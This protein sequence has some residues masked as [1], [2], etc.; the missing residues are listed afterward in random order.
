[1]HVAVLGSGLAGLT[2]AGLLARKGHRVSLYEQHPE[3]GGVTSGIGKDGFRWDLGQMLMPDLGP[4]E[5]GRSVLEELGISDQ[6]AVTRGCRANV[7]PDFAILRPD[8]CSGPYWRREFFKEIFPEDADG[9][10]RYYE[11]YDRVHDLLGLSNQSGLG[12]R[13][14][15]LLGALRIRRIKSWSAEQ[16]LDAFFSS[17]KLKAVFSHILADYSTYPRDFPGLIIPIINPEA[18]YDERV[19]LE[20]GGHTRRSS[21]TF[22]RNGTRAMVD[23]IAGAVT[24]YGGEIHLETEVTQIQV[25]DGRVT[26]IELDGEQRQQVDAVVASGGARELFGKLIGR[27]QLP[28]RF[29]EEHV[30]NLAVTSSVF[31]VHLGVDFDPSVHQNDQ[32]LCYYYSTYEV[33]SNI[34]ELEAGVYHEGRDGWV[35]YI[36]SK[37]SP[38]MAPPGHHAVT[39]YTVAPDKLADGSWAERGEELGDRLVSYAERYLPGLGEHTVTRVLYT[40]DD[41]RRRTALGA[42]AF[43]GVPPRVDRTPPRHRTP[44]RGL[45]FVGGQSEV[46]GGVTGA[47]TGA[48]KTVQMMTRRR[49]F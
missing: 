41:F 4:G 15:L 13:L 27:E 32:A 37:H 38:E 5:P 17:P 10:D 7:F 48:R 26:G 23:A 28:A 25:K 43:G 40:P 42:H 1:M 2:A 6:V 11:V 47:M 49:P 33:E 36:P 46:Y 8:S 29:L 3:I 16:F 20:Y 45:W 44:I 34:K 19:P 31:M 21:W 22:I 39:I 30:D 24:G 18:A 9:L 35:V 12:A 14:Q